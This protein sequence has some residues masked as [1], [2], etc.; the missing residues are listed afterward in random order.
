MRARACRK[1][2]CSSFTHG[3]FRVREKNVVDAIYTRRIVDTRVPT[4]SATTFKNCIYLTNIQN[5]RSQA[6]IG[7]FSLLTMQFE[8]PDIM[9]PNVNI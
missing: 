3:R 5:T 6:I 8:I 4:Y 1:T 7:A 2:A 9:K